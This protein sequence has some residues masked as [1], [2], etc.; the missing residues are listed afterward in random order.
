MN[1]RLKLCNGLNLW[2]KM[3]GK[4]RE[5]FVTKIREKTDSQVLIFF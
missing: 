5:M 2:S 1:E 3:F 4:C